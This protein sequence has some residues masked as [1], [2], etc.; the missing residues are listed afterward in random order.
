MKKTVTIRE[1]AEEAGVSVATV[2]RYLNK[3]GYVD[4][5]TG[6]VIAEIIKKRNYRPSR[7]AQ[8]LKTQKS[9]MIVLVVPDIQN[10]F[11]SKMANKIQQLTMSAGYTI[12]LF[13]TGGIMDQEVNCIRLAADIGADG[14][15]FVSVATH[16]TILKELKKINIPTVMVNSYDACP[17]DCVH[18]VRGQ[19]TYLSTKHLIEIGHKEIGFAGGAPGTVIAE[20]RKNGYMNAMKEYGLPIKEEFVFEMGF[21]SDAG[22]KCGYYFSALKKRPTAI[23][24]TNDMIAL[25]IYQ[26]FSQNGIR[27]PDDIAVTGMD[28]I[29]YST[30]CQPRL[31]T[32]TNDSNE[33]AKTAVKALLERMQKTYLGDPREFLISRELIV[34]ES[35]E[36]KKQI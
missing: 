23:C 19:S 36:D 3:S 5:A 18:G 1:I 15:I 28:N 16:L 10:P 32:V 6:E 35:T 30:L 14:I 22:I 7:M 12:T 21:N 11:Y 25:G 4:T 9:K 8:S 13:N 2:S 31:T 27:V 29:I 20:S 34:R 24:C 33:F 26:A 17:F